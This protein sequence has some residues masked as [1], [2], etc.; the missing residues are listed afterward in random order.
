MAETIPSLLSLLAR[1]G[2][3]EVNGLGLDEGALAMTESGGRMLK[4]LSSAGGGP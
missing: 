2:V 1:A 4:I 3:E